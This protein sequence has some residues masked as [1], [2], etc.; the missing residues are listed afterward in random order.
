MSKKNDKVSYYI[1]V[2][3]GSSRLCQLSNEL[4]SKNEEY[5]KVGG[6]DNFVGNYDE[7]QKLIRDIGFAIYKSK[8]PSNIERRVIHPADAFR[9]LADFLDSIDIEATIK[10]VGG[11]YNYNKIIDAAA[12]FHVNNAADIKESWN[13]KPV[14][15]KKKSSTKSSK[16]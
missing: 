11:L 7:Q 15:Q 16:K 9:N 3:S 10:S 13:P 12:S 8:E 2:V 14:H 4:F 5:G 1:D 6:V